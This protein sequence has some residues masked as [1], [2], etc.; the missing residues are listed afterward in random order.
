[1]TFA[2]FSCRVYASNEW[3]AYFIKYFSPSNTRVSSF[4]K[5][6]SVP[7]FTLHVAQK[8]SKETS[9]Q[10]EEKFLRTKL[11][12]SG[13]P[14]FFYPLISHL[15][16]RIFVNLFYLH[17]DFVLHASAVESHGRA[18]IFTGLSGAGKT[19]IANMSQHL[20]GLRVLADNQVFLRLKE[21][22][23]VMY[24][25]PFDS[26][27]KGTTARELPVGGIY[28]LSQSDR[29]KVERLAFPEM[30]E[31][32]RENVQLQV[33]SRVLESTLKFEGGSFAKN[34]FRLF[35]CVKIKRLKFAKK[36]GF[37][38]VIYAD[39]KKHEG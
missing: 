11:T 32:F 23:C 22:K 6:P 39:Q 15:V 29:H 30:L 17:G 26:F 19:T 36:E 14:Y 4:L 35:R 12:I 34:L 5:H 1:M 8:N 38:E 27:H 18:Y 10:L 33:P 9:V 20:Y 25:F 31:S 16:Q 37:W 3:R 21:G 7:H 24:P 28:I 2:G 13:S